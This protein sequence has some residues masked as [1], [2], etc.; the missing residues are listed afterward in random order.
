KKNK[1]GSI[2]EVKTCMDC[3]TKIS[4]TTQIKNDQ[5]QK[6]SLMQNQ[7]VAIASEI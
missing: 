1:N 3:R 2:K 5:K 6:E 7:E 4:S